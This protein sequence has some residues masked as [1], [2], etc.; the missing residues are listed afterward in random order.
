MPSTLSSVFRYDPSFIEATVTNVDP[1]RFT[2][3]VKTTRGQLLD[4][5]TWLLPTGGSGGTG[6]HFSPNVGDQVLLNTSLGYPLIIGCMP[7]PGLPRTDLTSISGSPLPVDTGNATSMKNGYTANPNKPSDF[8]PGDHIHTNDSGGALGILANGT[9]I[10]RASALAQILI[11]K[12][13][14]I[15]RIVARNFEKF[16]DFGQQTIANVGGRMYEFM[17]WDR[18]FLNSSQGIYELQDVIGDVAAGV[19]LQGNPMS[20]ATLPAKDSRVRQY[21]LTDDSGHNLMVELLDNLGDRTTTVYQG[22]TPANNT[23]TEIQAQSYTITTVGGGVT[24]S[25]TITPTSILINYNNVGEILMN[26]SEVNVNYQGAVVNLSANGVQNTF[27][28]HFLNVNSAGV[29]LG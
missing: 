26:S 1:I 10:A 6:A 7:R 8:V 13:D 2:C 12:F 5:I 24:A 22:G 16:T 23:S 11:S 14:D 15:V 17:G 28:G 29:T 19:T 20:G 4:S 21:S 3:S 9:V 27:N 18:N 25:I